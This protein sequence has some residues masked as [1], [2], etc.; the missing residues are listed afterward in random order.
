MRVLVTGGAGF[1]GSHVV[2]ALLGE[3]HSVAVVDDLSA[4][5]PENIDPQARLYRASITDA[6]SLERVFADE[7]PQIVN[8]HSAQTD[9]RASL[10]DPLSDARVNVLGTVNLLQLSVKHD[11]TRF[12]FASTCAVYSEPSYMPMDE[13]HPVKPQ[14]GYGMS[15]H[16]AEG[17]ITLYGDTYGL[18]YK[19][20][21]YGNVY[22]PRQ[23]PKGEAGVVAIF[24]GQLLTGIQ[25]TIFGDGSKTRDYIYV[26]DIA[27]A[28][29][30]A[31]DPP[32][33]FNVFN[34]ASGLEV[35]DDDI[36]QAVGD[37]VGANVSPVYAQKRPGEADRVSLDISKAE[38]LLGWKPTVALG[39][40]VRRTVAYY[41]E[42]LRQSADG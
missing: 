15:K 29:L 38:K 34:L 14:S 4:G 10:A 42:R 7:R 24:A 40:G 35:S 11:V 28:N 36:F 22:G 1:I 41:A 3:G 17:Y 33:D 2:D 37:S 9:V 13:S 31:V 6:E 39:E 5:T 25:S 19:I 21:R 12:I 20:F 30:M 26:G 18:K 32:G 27:R 23:N 8:H 16:A